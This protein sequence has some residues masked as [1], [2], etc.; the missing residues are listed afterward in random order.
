[1][2]TMMMSDAKMSADWMKMAKPLDHC[3]MVMAG[4]DGKVRGRHFV[5]RHGQGMREDGEVSASVSGE[6]LRIGA[7]GLF[8][9]IA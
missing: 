4:K 5:R 8:P 1:M 3:M 2:G 7:L 9:S 6:Q